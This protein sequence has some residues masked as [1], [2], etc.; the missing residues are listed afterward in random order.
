LRSSR[1]MT[2][3]RLGTTPVGRR[4]QR[5]S[6]GSWRNLSST[7]QGHA[8]VRAGSRDGCRLRKA[9]RDD[10]VYAAAAGFPWPIRNIVDSRVGGSRRHARDRSHAYHDR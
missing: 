10:Q 5:M 2:I 4:Q 9:V 7:L 6:K 3:G 1:S 8:L